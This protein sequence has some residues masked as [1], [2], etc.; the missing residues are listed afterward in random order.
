M[1]FG[2]ALQTNGRNFGQDS[3]SHLQLSQ[4][5]QNLERVMN[6]GA[7]KSVL[8]AYNQA[9]RLGWQ[10]KDSRPEGPGAIIRAM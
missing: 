9:S 10:R 6:F 7:D 1:E 3:R 2:V 5:N 4:A 8:F